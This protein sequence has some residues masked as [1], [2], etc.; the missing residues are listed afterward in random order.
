MPH[1]DERA[2]TKLAKG[3]AKPD[4]I[5]RARRE[6]GSAEAKQAVSAV[7]AAA[8]KLP[9]DPAALARPREPR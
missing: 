1:H 4:D 5:D 6:V 3:A 2:P 7:Q 8:L 9:N